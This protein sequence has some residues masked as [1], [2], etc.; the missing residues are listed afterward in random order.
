VEQPTSVIVCGRCGQWL[1]VPSDLG[2]LHVTCPVCHAQW[3]WSKPRLPWVASLRSVRKWLLVPLAPA[4][5]ICRWLLSPFRLAWGWVSDHDKN[6]LVKWLVLTLAAPVV[7]PVGCLA[8][9][10]ICLWLVAECMKKQVVPLLRSS[11]VGREVGPVRRA[12][13]IG[14]R[15]LVV[16]CVCAPF[17]MRPRSPGMTLGGVTLT[18]PYTPLQCGPGS[19]AGD[20]VGVGSHRWVQVL[21][22]MRPRLA[23]RG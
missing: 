11:P 2:T 10:L 19:L 4:R 22:S 3:S 20:D 1:G 17:V 12:A 9:L 21:P 6:P 13:V 18:L 14:A 7:L 15:V 23:R 5:L 16:A 8:L